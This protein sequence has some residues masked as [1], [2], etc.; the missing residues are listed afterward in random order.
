MK[1]V[2]FIMALA[3]GILTNPAIAKNKKNEKTVTFQVNIDCEGCVKKIKGN[4]PYEKGIK[5]LKVSLEKKECTVTYRTDVTNEEKIKKAFGKLG[6]TASCSCAQNTPC[7]SN[8]GDSCDKK[9]ECH[10]KEKN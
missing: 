6:Y 4:I 3:V 7:S 2:L 8:C 5:D 10:P 1:R 9:H